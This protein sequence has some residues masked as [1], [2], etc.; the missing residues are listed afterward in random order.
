ML[1]E[2]ASRLSEPPEL[3]V[4]FDGCRDYERILPAFGRHMFLNQ[5][6]TPLGLAHAARELTRSLRNRTRVFSL[7]RGS[8]V[9]M[10]LMPSKVLN[11][12][13]IAGSFHQLPSTDS[14]G[15][16]SAIEDVAVRRFCRHADLITA[17]S[18]RA[19]DEI[20]SLG[21]ARGTRLEYVPNPIPART[22][23]PIAHIAR[24][25][26]P[27]R[28]LFVGRVEEQKGLGTLSTWLRNIDRDVVVRFVGEGA[29]REQ[30]RESLD[31]LPRIRQEWVGRTDEVWP[32]YD[33]SD[34]VILPS[35]WE[36]NPVVVWEAW[37]SGRPVISSTLPVFNDL[38]ET[39]PIYPCPSD[40]SIREL[41]EIVTS[42]E[43][44]RR[45]F[46][47]ASVAVS[48]RREG[49]DLVQFLNA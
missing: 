25:P 23:R 24:K 22:A 10:G 7:M 19:V 21:W 20:A 31:Q 29:S 14:S 2:L 13:S 26:D 12:L 32:H 17:P 5:P 43:Q 33:W 39:G 40:A 44:M 48:Q 45:D 41:L 15:W 3:I 28:L 8:H 46:D 38:Q 37:A 1:Y 42:T 18:A 16:R 27:V 34:I 4:L 35:R 36:L 47:R 11:E 30:V 49:D 6:R 9:A